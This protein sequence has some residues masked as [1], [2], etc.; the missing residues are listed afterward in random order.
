MSK[1]KNKLIGLGF[2]AFCLVLLSA[3]SAGASSNDLQGEW[4]AQTADQKNVSLKF[5]KDTVTVD[6]EE[7]S[8]KQKS[9]ES[10][11]NMTYYKIE[12]NGGDYSVIFPEKDKNIAIMIQPDS[13]NDDLSG[14]M[15]YAMNKKEQPNYKEYAEKYMQ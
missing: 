14:T 11:N 10:K 9:A 5:D 13:S 12:Q 8:Y 1:I 3:C 6:G 4:K 15:L 7:F 2:L